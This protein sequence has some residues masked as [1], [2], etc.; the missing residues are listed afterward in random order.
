MQRM[1]SSDPELL[2][3][4]G[5]SRTYGIG[6]KAIRRAAER[7]EFPVYAAGTAWPRVR[8]SEIETWIASTRLPV[9]RCDRERAEM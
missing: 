3:L 7:G 4:P 8:R 2:T 9:V 5:V 1:P 6:I